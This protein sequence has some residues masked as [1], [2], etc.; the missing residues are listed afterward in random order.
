MARLDFKL[1]QD[2]VAKGFGGDASAVRDKKDRGVG[3]GCF[4]MDRAQT[5][6]YNLA[7]I[8]IYPWPAVSAPL[9]KHNS[10][11]WNRLHM[12]QPGLTISPNLAHHRF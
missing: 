7:I 10:A 11:V 6:A 8:Q 1:G 9:K 5:R 2:G 12:G 4:Q 3:H